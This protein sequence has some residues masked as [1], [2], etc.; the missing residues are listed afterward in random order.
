M[1]FLVKVSCCN[2]YS[3][4]CDISL[5][6][7]MGIRTNCVG[8]QKVNLSD[9]DIVMIFKNLDFTVYYDSVCSELTIYI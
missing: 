6:E 5:L 7:S 3:F 1:E 2:D 8:I 4:Q 9:E